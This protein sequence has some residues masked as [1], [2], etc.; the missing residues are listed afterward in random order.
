[1][2]N[3]E[4]K[5]P[6]DWFKIGEEDL[7]ASEI[8]LR[9]QSLKI[10]AFHLQQSLEKFL[11]GYLLFHGWELKR[12][13]DLEQL[14]DEAVGYDPDFESYRGLCQTTTEYYIDE[15]Y[16]IFLD[17]ELGTDELNLM[18]TRVKNLIEKIKSE[19]K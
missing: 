7:K 3:K 10:A 2:D 19:V 14:L 16:P 15:R 13:H 6:K 18:I 4:S 9:E 8:L 17:S 5:I 12:T 1:M 11:K